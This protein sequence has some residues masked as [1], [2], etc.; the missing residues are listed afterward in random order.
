MDGN[1]TLTG[2]TLITPPASASALSAALNTNPHL[3]SLPSPKPN[4]LAPERL[5]QTTGTAEIFRLPQ[6]R[7][8]ITGDFIVLPCDLV[9]ELGG[10]SL[11][12]TWMI[13]QAG[14]GGATRS[15]ERRVG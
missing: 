3:T 14:L 1:N 12:E 5:D 15:E 7:A 4:L 6:V 13:K 10:E 8:A 11:L 9:C 2:I